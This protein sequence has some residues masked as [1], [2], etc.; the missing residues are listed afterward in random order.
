MRYF[1][2]AE[3]TRLF[4]PYNVTSPRNNPDFARENW[5]YGLGRPVVTVFVEV[6]KPR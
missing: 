6:T 3:L 2:V 4:A 5:C 1:S